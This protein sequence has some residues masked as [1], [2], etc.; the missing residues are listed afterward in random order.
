MRTMRLPANLGMLLLAIF[1]ICWGAMF[2]LGIG[3]YAFQVIVALLAI[4]AGIV[5]L[6]DFRWRVSP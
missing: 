1:L 2:L 4:A 6:L 5:L 3:T